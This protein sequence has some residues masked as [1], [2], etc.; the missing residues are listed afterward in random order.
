MY[1]LLDPE[2][3]TLPGLLKVF[4]RRGDRGSSTARSSSRRGSLALRMADIVNCRM[5]S[6]RSVSGRIWVASASGQT[7]P[8]VGIVGRSEVSREL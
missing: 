8:D 6:I 1:A 3:C 4:T 2:D 5:S 7:V